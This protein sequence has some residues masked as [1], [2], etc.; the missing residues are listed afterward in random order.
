MAEVVEKLRAESAPREFEELAVAL[1]VMADA[2]KRERGLLLVR[3]PRGLTR[4]S[5]LAQARDDLAES[6]LLPT[7]I[8]RLALSLAAFGE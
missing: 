5:V 7:E 2:D 3:V 6:G 4:A 1:T 8:D